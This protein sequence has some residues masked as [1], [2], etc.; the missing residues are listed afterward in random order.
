MTYMEPAARMRSSARP[1]VEARCLAVPLCTA[2][3]PSVLSVAV[4]H[5]RLLTGR[6][7][8][9]AGKGTLDDLYLARADIFYPLRQL[10]PYSGRSWHAF[11][12]SFSGSMYSPVKNNARSQY[13]SG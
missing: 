2:V 8:V 5:I 11:G 6:L 4:P 10:I 9:F 1:Y 12:S 7:R 3:S 13:S